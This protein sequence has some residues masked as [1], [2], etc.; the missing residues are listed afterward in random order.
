MSSGLGR[1]DITC[2]SCPLQIEVRLPRVEL[3]YRARHGKWAVYPLDD[4]L[5]KPL[6]Y[7]TCSTYNESSVGFALSCIGPVVK[8]LEDRQHEEWEEW[9]AAHPEEQPDL[10]PLLSAL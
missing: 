9:V 7:G 8:M 1:L 6:A 3:Y 4:I 2:P 10:G 5:G